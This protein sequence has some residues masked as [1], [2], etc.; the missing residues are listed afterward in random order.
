MT[1]TERCGLMCVRH[2]RGTR[3][4][5]TNR[6]IVGLIARG[7]DSEL[8]Y[9]LLSSGYT[10]SKLKNKNKIELLSLGIPEELTS[11]ILNDGR[12]PIPS[13]TVNELLY[14]CRR[15]C[16]ICRKAG[17]S[18]IIHHINPWHMSR[19]HHK[20]NLAILCLNCHSEA[21]TKRD[22]AV[23]LTPE[24][25]KFCKQKW[26]EQV[27]KD[28]A[29]ALFTPS[30]WKL[31]SGVWDYFNHNRLP[32]L[33]KEGMIKLSQI[34]GYSELS[35]SGIIASDGSVIWPN[36]PSPK[37]QAAR[38]MYDGGMVGPNAILYHF[39]KSLVK[40]ILKNLPWVDLTYEWSKS[41]ITSLVK[42]GMICACTGAFR[43]KWHHKNEQY[44][45][46]QMR[47]GYKKKDGIRL[48]YQFDGWETVSSSS[49]DSHLSGIWVCTSLVL[50]RTMLKERGSINLNC[51]ALAIGTGFT[52]YQGT[53]PA[54]AW[55]DDDDEDDA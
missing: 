13:E 7:F 11:K 30:S 4:D 31:T 5:M 15:T 50:V 26:I 9:R 27:R 53:V 38:Y 51:T 46:G 21:H 52:E 24:H 10:I 25:I 55:E 39:N 22:L 36:L 14:K 48:S 34:Q 19:S 17:Q 2:L 35:S 20:N 42:P 47:T 16:C 18:V 40:E 49:H 33:A 44:G 3:I 41:Q 43:F 1:N 45:P 12:P 23:D 29:E 28:D 37:I 32:V 6:T 8:A 54:V